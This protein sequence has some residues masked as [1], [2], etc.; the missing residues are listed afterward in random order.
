LSDFEPDA[1]SRRGNGKEVRI[2]QEIILFPVITFTKGDY[3]QHSILT[4][5][6]CILKAIARKLSVKGI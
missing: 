1:G 4:I 5:L 6:K 2:G 3:V